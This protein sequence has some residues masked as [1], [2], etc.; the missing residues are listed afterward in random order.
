MTGYYS[1]RNIDKEISNI[2]QL[3]PIHENEEEVRFGTRKDP[4]SSPK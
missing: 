3:V 4:T 1:T 2:Q